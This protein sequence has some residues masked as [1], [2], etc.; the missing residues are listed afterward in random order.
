MATSASDSQTAVNSFF[1]SPLFYASSE[2]QQGCSGAVEPTV[3]STSVGQSDEGGD[4]AVISTSADPNA[5]VVSD[6]AVIST[7]ADQGRAK[8]PSKA[9]AYDDEELTCDTN[10]V[11][12]VLISTSADQ[13]DEGGGHAVISTSVDPD[14]EAT[15]DPA[16]ISTSTDQ[17]GANIPFEEHI[18]AAE[19]VMHADIFEEEDAARNATVSIPGASTHPMITRTP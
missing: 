5:E 9:H 17:G 13:P 18:C 14:V 12:P 6:P 15:S 10:F 3:I 19:F 8:I 2:Y 1:Q 4:H 16:V 7:S 11:K